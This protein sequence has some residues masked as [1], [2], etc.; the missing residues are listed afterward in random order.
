MVE[1][2]PLGGAMGA[3]VF[4]VDLSAPVAD[5]VAAALQAA[6]NEHILLLFR[7]QELDDD[8]L[9]KSANWLGD[10]SHIHMPEERRVGGDFN[11]H[12]ISNIR[13]EKGEEIGSF[14]DSDMW[15][16]HDNCFA[17][18]P[19]KATWLYAVELPETG[20]N[21]LFRNCYLSWEELPQQLKEKITGKQVLQVYDYT[22]Q[23]KPDLSDLTDVPHCWQPAVLIHP[24]TGRPALYI[25]RLMSAAIE[26]M[27][28][29]EADTLLQK[30]FPYIERCD[31]EH[32]W[33]LGDYVIWDNRCSAHARTAFPADQRRLLKRGKVAGCVV[34]PWTKAA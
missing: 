15:F 13:N 11:I 22:V 16:H 27:E 29:E 17:E 3:E 8:Q 2:K 20:G 28:A 10:L 24:E 33:Q 32:H 1:I 5:D 14:G 4:G 25:N 12:L 19:D 31:Y 6:F 21:T 7:E 9:K 18:A 34:E 26:G 30:L 23:E